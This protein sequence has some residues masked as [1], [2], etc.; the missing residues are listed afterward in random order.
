MKNT[1]SNLESFTNIRGLIIDM[2]GVL[3]HGNQPLAGLNEFFDLLRE[4]KIPFILATNNSTLTQTEYV[5]KLRKMKVEVKNNEVLTSSMVTALYLAKHYPPQENKLFMIGEAG[6]KE[7][8]LAQGYYLKGVDETADADVV[9]CGLDRQLEWKQLATATLTIRAGAKFIATNGD[10]TL[11]TEKGL[12][13][14][15]GSII[16]ALKTATGG[17]S[18]QTLGKPEPLMYQDALSLL[19]T[20]AAETI[21]IGDRLDT[22]ILGSVRAGIRSVMVLTGISSENDIQHVGYQP[23]WIMDDIKVLTQALANLTSH[24]P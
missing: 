1:H 10:T 24:N 20:E 7:A 16:E 2:D 22:D 4:K 3:W 9:V 21:T 11:P 18:A 23:T 15:N 8:L 13:P 14:G 17:I 6:L 12:V 19:K 5:T